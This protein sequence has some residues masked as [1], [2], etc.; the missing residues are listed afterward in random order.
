MSA[1]PISQP[2]PGVLVKYE[3]GYKIDGEFEH[4]TEI[5]VFCDLEQ[6]PALDKHKFEFVDERAEHAGSISNLIFR[7]KIKSPY[8]CPG[9]GVNS[10]SFW[11]FGIGA[12][13]LIALAGLLLLYLVIGM[14]IMKFKFKK[15]GLE[16][17]PNFWFWKTVPGLVKDGVLL[18]AEG[19]L[20][21]VAKCKT[22]RA[23]VP[24]Y[25]S[26]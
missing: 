12:G 3:K 15:T 26:L 19:V 18:V 8:A 14:I 11:R 7:F 9:Y 13:V 10:S 21:L 22:N 16:I 2:F 1:Q 4:Q 25:D 23:S 5:Q 20:F 17:I 24:Q 6:D